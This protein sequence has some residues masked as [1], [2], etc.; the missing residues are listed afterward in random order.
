MYIKYGTNN[1]SDLAGYPSSVRGL[2]W[3]EGF[4]QRRIEN[5]RG[6][7]DL[8]QKR[9]VIAGE[10]VV[11]DASLDPQAD[12]NTAIGALEAVL[13]GAAA[14][15]VFTQDDGAGTEHW[16]DDSA[17][18][19]GVGLVSGPDYTDSGRTEFAT[20][21]KW[22]ATFEAEFDDGTPENLV[23]EQITIRSTG[24][25]ARVVLAEVASG[26]AQQ[27][28][29]ATA[30]VGTKTV[31]GVRIGRDSLP[32]APSASGYASGG[33]QDTQASSVGSSGPQVV[34]GRVTNY[35]RTWNYVYRKSG[36]FVTFS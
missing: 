28:T 3:L 33:I 14:D 5:R 24:G 6:N 8:V 27:F 31:S 18:V 35:V 1:L 11:D 10:L 34:G 9:M 13:T 2:S 17:S 20:G 22:Q 21:R 15:L 19:A 36:G 25:G 23:F 4:T 29:L 30:T 26:A 16:L 7:P 32:D 12:I